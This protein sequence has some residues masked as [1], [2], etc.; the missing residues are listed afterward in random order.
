MPYYFGDLIL[1]RYTNFNVDQM[2]MVFVLL[3]G[4]V[5]TEGIN[6][7]YISQAE[8]DY[9]MGLITQFPSNTGNAIYYTLKSEGSSILRAYRK[10]FTNLLF[11]II[12]K[13]NVVD[14][15]YSGEDDQDNQPPTKTTQ[16]F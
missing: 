5:H 8:I 10:Y 11:P 3:S 4:P 2:P 16:E 12:N 7:N 1:A 9:L 14:L 15:M 6:S 13:W